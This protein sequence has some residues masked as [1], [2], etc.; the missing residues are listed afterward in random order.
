[1]P[2]AAL[3]RRGAP[4][5]DGLRDDRH[6]RAVAG[7]ERLGVLRAERVADRVGLVAVDDV[8]CE[9]ERL[10]LL[11]QRLGRLLVADRVGLAVARCS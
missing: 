3:E 1:M 10:E 9:A 5:L 2:A 4:A 6:R 8:D 11:G 7:L